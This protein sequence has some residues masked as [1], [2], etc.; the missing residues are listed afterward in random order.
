M[1]ISELFVRKPVMTTLV[2]AAV[3]AF[4]IAAYF[5]L[6]ISDLPSVDYPVITINVAYPGASP[7]MMAATVASPLEAQCM[8]IP[9][10]V[11]I[12]S[13]NTEGQTKITLTFDLDRSSDLAGAADGPHP[14]RLVRGADRGPRVRR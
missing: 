14:L 11:S 6:P 5:S 12:I 4:G 2:T 9:G 10:L 3:T 7:Q 13:D 1:N 8:Q